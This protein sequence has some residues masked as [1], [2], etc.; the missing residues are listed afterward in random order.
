MGHGEWIQNPTKEPRAS[1]EY[2]GAFL[3]ACTPW[4]HGV[5]YE[6]FSNVSSVSI[7]AED[8]PRILRSSN[9]LIFATP[10]Q[11][12]NRGNST[13][14]SR[15][16][17]LDLHDTEEEFRSTPHSQYLKVKLQIGGAKLQGGDAEL[18]MPY[19]PE[20]V[21]PHFLRSERCFHA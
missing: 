13:Y 20:E 17:H 21:T 16:L 15:A 10:G 18:N 8:V 2:S 12:R 6:P 5:P 11:A 4:N 7:K 9:R 1:D 19:N 14:K 3:G